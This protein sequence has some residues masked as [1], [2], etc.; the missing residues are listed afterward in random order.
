MPF[1][2]PSYQSYDEFKYRASPTL[3]LNQ[4]PPQQDET[5]L[6][7]MAEPRQKFVALPTD[8]FPL[9]NATTTIPLSRI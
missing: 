1:S 2:P 9:A 6:S 7:K 3:Y 8:L 4:N 5:D